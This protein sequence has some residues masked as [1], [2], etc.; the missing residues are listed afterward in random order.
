MAFIG[1]ITAPLKKAIMKVGRKNSA[2]NKVITKAYEASDYKSRKKFVSD[3]ESAIVSGEKKTPIKI[4]K[5]KKK[6]PV[7]RT[8][9]EEAELNRLIREQKKDMQAGEKGELGSIGGA[10]AGGRQRKTISKPGSRKGKRKVPDPQNRLR[11]GDKFSKDEIANMTYDEV[12]EYIDKGIGGSALVN[13]NRMRNNVTKAQLEEIE[14]MVKGGELSIAR[15]RGGSTKPQVKK[16]AWMK[17]LSED[18]IKEMLG[19]PKPS[20][21]RRTNLK[22]KKKPVQMAKA[23]KKVFRRGGGQALRGFGKATYSNKL[24]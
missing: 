10:G 13:A 7:E 22:K 3:V 2:E 18:R 11:S 5:K 24:Y 14:G 21:E 4:K 1:K 23:S 16:P 12:Q 17:G 6:A 20:G 8:R 15:K 9:K 19:G